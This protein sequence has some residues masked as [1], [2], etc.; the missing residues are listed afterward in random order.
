M[1]SREARYLL[2]SPEE[3]PQSFWN[4]IQ[5]QE[6]IH[7]FPYQRRMAWDLWTHLLAPAPQRV[8]HPFLIWQTWY[9]RED[10]QRIF[11]YLYERLSRKDRWDRRLF[12]PL[13]IQQGLDWNDRSQFQD[14]GWSTSRFDRWLSTFDT[15][16]KQ[17]SIPGMQ[18][19]LFNRTAMTF[20]LEQYP[21]LEQCY[22]QRQS[23]K[24]CSDLS[25]PDQSVFLKT[26]WRRSEDGFTLEFFPTD[27]DSLRQQWQE[28]H[29]TADSKGEPQFDETFAIRTQSGLK[30]HLVA[31]HAT[32][33]VAGQ[34]F[35]SSIW[36]GRDP[37]KDFS[38]EQP[39]QWLKPWISYRMCSVYGLHAPLREQSI[40]SSWPAD[41]IRI[42]QELQT[43]A[44]PNWCSNP[45]LEPGIN[46]QKTNC[47]GC[48]QFAGLNWNQQE[49]KRRLTTDLPSLIQP[50][51]VNGPSDFIWSLFVGPEPLI[52][53]IMDSLE[54]FD[55][56][57]PYQQSVESSDEKFLDNRH[58]QCERQSGPCPNPL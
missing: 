8:A 20:I 32:L 18:K 47:S 55:V 28:E 29:W 51:P 15:D 33:K 31:M 1:S 41:L 39:E 43:L 57:D 21:A 40:E 37:A 26:A 19:I 17:K 30:F 6:L 36:L 54:Y 14:S 16:E 45:Y 22:R 44:E 42:A 52:F 10:L 7:D 34:W 4:S 50:S 38:A 56:Y 25:L 27:V 46:N 13:E 5:S 35:W 53:P 9:S 24:I 3:L 49:F 58:S 11:R 12:T 2:Q 48:H 23:L